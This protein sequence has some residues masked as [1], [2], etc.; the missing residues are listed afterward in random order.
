MSQDLLDDEFLRPKKLDQFVGQTKIKEL[1]SVTIQAAKNRGEVL[2]HILLYGP[3]GLGKTTLGNIIANEMETSIKTLSAPSI[4]KTGELVGVLTLLKPGEILF[5]DEIHRLPRTI[6]EVLYSAMEDYFVNIIINRDTE[7]KSIKININPFT[8]IGA[9]TRYGSLGGPFRDR[10]G[11]ALKV[12]YYNLTEIA[13]IIRRTSKI[14]DLAIDDQ[15]TGFLAKASRATPRIA[16]RIFKRVRDFATVENKRNIDQ[17]LAIKVLD[18]LGIAESG[19]NADD[20]AF[21]QTIMEQY[22]GGPVGIANLATSLNE[23]PT[24]IEDIIEPYLIKEGYVKRTNKGRVV[25][26]KTYKLFN[27]WHN[28]G[29]LD[30]S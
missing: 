13:Q 10:F 28:L 17:S 30:E 20:L 14:L 12:E 5:I 3:A 8:L 7:P 26:D 2:D 9:T 27:L 11:L 29:I 22:G 23:D 6:E 24:T 16:N 1:L 4:E 19:L 25:T 15:A 18:K 21:L